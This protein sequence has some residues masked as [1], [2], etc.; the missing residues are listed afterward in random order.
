MALAIDFAAF[1]LSPNSTYILPR[2]PW[3]AAFP[4]SSF[5]IRPNQGGHR[6]EKAVTRPLSPYSGKGI[7]VAAIL[8]ASI[9]LR[10]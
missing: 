6:D 2:S 3:A 7:E 8:P 10:P 5:T 1:A 4:G 9:Y